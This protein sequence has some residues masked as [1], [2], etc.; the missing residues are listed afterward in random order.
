MLNRIGSERGGQFSR[1]LC[2]GEKGNDLRGVAWPG[3]AW[4]GVAWRGGRAQ[5]GFSS[6]EAHF[7]P[8]Y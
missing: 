2:C 5:A 4:P 6:P 7:K 3:V 1:N 8:Q